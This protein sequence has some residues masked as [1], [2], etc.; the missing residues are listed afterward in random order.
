MS[1]SALIIMIP[2]WAIVTFFTVW[3]FAKILKKK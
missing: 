2:V 3:F 1:T